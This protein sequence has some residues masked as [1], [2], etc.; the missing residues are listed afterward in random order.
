LLILPKYQNEELV[1]LL[2]NF[3]L[4]RFCMGFILHSYETGPVPWRPG[5]IQLLAGSSTSTQFSI[6]SA[7]SSFDQALQAH[8]LQSV[9]PFVGSGLVRKWT[10]R[11]FI[12]PGSD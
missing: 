3:D 8:F 1:V 12:Y 10:A 5:T 9:S 6:F 4:T 11:L 2:G 7:E